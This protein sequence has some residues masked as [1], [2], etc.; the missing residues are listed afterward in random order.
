MDIKKAVR[1]CHR[2]NIKGSLV[3]CGVWKGIQ[4]VRACETILKYDLPLMD[5][6]LY[7]TFEG[8]PAPTKE[9]FKLYDK[10]GACATADLVQQRWEAKRFN[11]KN[12]KEIKGGWCFCSLKDVKSNI[13]KT[14]YPEEKLH[15]V[16]GDVMETLKNPEN[17]PKEIAI[18]RLD[19]D[20]YKS[21]KYE[22]EVL[23]KHV[24]PGGFIIFDDYN[25]WN[26]QRQATDEF[27]KENNI[28]IDEKNWIHYKIQYYPILE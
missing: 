28:T 9:D 20:W 7:D 2:D 1:Y 26:G 3:E 11:P 4:I 16:K 10:D 8:M 22:L 19:T 21:S 14:K 27:F 24:V 6:Y 12:K 17:Y 18:L 5:I 25:S 13:N 23:Y 15:Y